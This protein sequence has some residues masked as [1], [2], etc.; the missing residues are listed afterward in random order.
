M[1]RLLV[2][3]SFTWFSLLLAPCVMAQDVLD[4]AMHDELARSVEKLRIE[5]LDKPYF[6]A[7]RVLD[8]SEQGVRATFGSLSE[9]SQSHNRFAV[10]EV[11]VGDYKLDNTNF[12]SPSVFGRR[13]AGFAVLPLDDD[14]NELRRHLW[15]A[16]DDAYKYALEQLSQKRAFLQNKN[17]TQEVPDLTREEP[18]QASDVIPPPSNDMTAAAALVRDLS[19]LFR[20]MPDVFN[21][22]VQL[23]E[24][25]T[26]VRY[27]NSEGTSVRYS[28]P[29]ATFS[30]QA[31][32]QAADG[33]PLDDSMAVHARS[34]RE[35]PAKEALAGRIKDLGA[36]LEQ[37]RGSSTI[38][39][40]DGPVLVE[41]EAAPQ[42]FAQVFAPKLLAIHPVLTDSPQFERMQ[43]DSYSDKIGARVLSSFLTV[44]D[45]PSLDL[46]SGKPL[47]GGYK[48]DYEGVKP[49]ET[50]VIEN[51]ILKTL[52][53]TRS[54]ARGI[55]HS[56]AN[57]RGSG[58]APS[59][60]IVT[61]SESVTS[62]ALRRKL[63]EL[64]KQR[65]KD[66]GIIVRQ[67][68]GSGAGVNASAGPGGA[69]RMSN[70]VSVY[71]LFPDNHEELVRNLE[72][73]DLTPSTFKDVLAVSDSAAVYSAPFSFRS[74]YATFTPG[75]MT[76]IVSWVVPS[77]LFEDL[78]MKTPT[79]EFPNPPAAKHPY[80]DKGKSGE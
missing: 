76:P 54:P 56:T 46:F 20:E 19:T 73:T 21:S 68:H 3:A 30:V 31:S 57:R 10:V 15:L 72:F 49:G 41:G 39:L 25:V 34:F 33:M 12:F 11:R 52:L 53:S 44:K 45:N 22:S 67:V 29:W 6:I 43:G 42:L 14:Y 63:L 61:S 9:R 74:P 5:G 32:T 80:F 1:N 23:S 60:L 70:L 50:V 64:V 77:M 7:Y 13:P 62:D 47:L 75:D 26:D 4:K 79:G 69:V 55:T 66:Y 35:L 40:Y 37:L 18:L 24:N 28:R 71:K 78:P 48:V 2:I 8:R 17:R 51:G 16:T 59:N 27:L 65:G 36:H 58:A 38:E